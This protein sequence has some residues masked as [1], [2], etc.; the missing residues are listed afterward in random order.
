MNTDHE[1]ER[2]IADFYATEAPSRAPDRVLESALATIDTT[3]Q[4]RALIRVPRRFP[5]M[6]IYAKVAV[7][8]VAVIA[9]AGFGLVMFRPGTDTGIG[10]P[11]PT[12]SPIVSPSPDP[13]A[14]PPLGGTFTSAI[15]GISISYPT[16]WVVIPATEAWTASS[17]H[18]FESPAVDRIHDP[19]LR[20]HLWL[21]LA[22]QPLA[23]RT[24][25]TFVTEFLDSPGIGCGDAR[26]PITVGGAS[27]LLCSDCYGGGVQRGSRLC[28]LAL[29]LGR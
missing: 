3:R 29:H 24:G 19:V 1:L 28:D 7:A 12:P 15:H 11:D 9:V 6:N 16:G 20:D 2:R 22:S 23:G 8:A 5:I 10:A 4:R 25:E 17:E 27:G 13:S 21:G 14:P 18:S 26:Q